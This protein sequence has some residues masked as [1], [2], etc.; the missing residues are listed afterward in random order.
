[1][2]VSLKIMHR[3]VPSLHRWKNWIRG[4]ASINTNLPWLKE[5]P[6]TELLDTPKKNPHSKKNMHKSASIISNKFQ[7]NFATTTTKNNM[8]FSVSRV[9]SFGEKKHLLLDPPPPP[10]WRRTSHHR[11]SPQFWQWGE[12]M[13][14]MLHDDSWNAASFIDKSSGKPNVHILLFNICIYVNNN[15]CIQTVYIF[16]CKVYLYIIYFYLNLFIYH[17]YIILSYPTFHHLGGKAATL[18]LGTWELPSHHPCDGRSWRWPK[19]G[20]PE[21]R[22]SWW[23]L[24]W[25]RKTWHMLHMGKWLGY[26]TTLI[27]W[28]SNIAHE[29]TVYNTAVRAF[30][31]RK[32]EVRDFF[33][34]LIILPQ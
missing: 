14:R 34:Q 24:P 1:M 3:N 20:P 4:E 8:F 6:L 7:W 19:G 13:P 15:M 11:E 29:T 10:P 18:P 5:R 33:K 26:I 27:T 2:L 30:L 31:S 9:D 32:P 12:A 28:E 21:K 25:E 22:C 23:N 17:Q 16:I